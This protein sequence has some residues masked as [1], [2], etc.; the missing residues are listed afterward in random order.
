MGLAGVG[1][2]CRKEERERGLRSRRS[3]YKHSGT[4][5]CCFIFNFL[6]VINDSNNI[7][8]KRANI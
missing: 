4:G 2:N 7:S 5:V 6:L 1:V 8:L 3:Y